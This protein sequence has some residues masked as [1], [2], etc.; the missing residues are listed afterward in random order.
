MVRSIKRIKKGEEVCVS[1]TDLLQPKAMRQSYLWFNHQFTCSCS[2]CTVS[3]S[4]L[5]DHALEEILASNPSFSSA[6]LDLNLYRD[7]ANKKLSHYVDETITEFLS[8]GDPESCCK[9]LERVLKGGFHVEQLESKDGKSRLNCKFHPF[10]HIAL[11]SY[12]TLASAYRIRS[13]DFLSFHSKTDESQL[14]AFEM[15]RISAG[16][17]IFINHCWMLCLEL[18]GVAYIRAVDSCEV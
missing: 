3:P 1:Y 12:M 16:G 11:N 17:G 13:S 18:I 14:K 2:R 5:V 4:T 10:N 6:G 8:V 7:E 15:S 9:K